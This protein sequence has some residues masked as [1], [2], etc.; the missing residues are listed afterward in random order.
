ML[1]NYLNTI[2]R[3]LRKNKT[4]SAINILG[5]ALAMSACLIIA[6]F[7][8][9][10]LGFDRYHS[11]A[12]RI[13]RIETE[14]WQEDVYQG[15]G[16]RSSP[17]M[18]QALAE[19]L[20]VVEQRAR[21]WDINYRNN[22]LTTK[23]EG[24]TLTYHEEGVYGAD[25]EVFAVFD[26]E[27][28][29]GGSD[30]FDEPG[31]MILTA[32][33]AI[34]YFE[35]FQSAIGTTVEMNGNDGAR[36]FEIVGI[37]QDLPAQTH[38]DFS[39]LFSMATRHMEG[40]E[41]KESWND[42]DTP[43]YLLLTSTEAKGVVLEEIQRLYDEHLQERF[44][45]Y[46]YEIRHHLIDLEDIHLYSRA[47]G[48]FNESVDALLVYGLLGVALI[49][50]IV[51][52]INYLNLSLVKTLDRLKEIGVRK[53]LGSHTKQITMLFTAEAAIVNVTA[54]LLAMT[55][56]Q[57][58]S[59][60]TQQLTGVPFSILDAWDVL[61]GLLATIIVGA[62]FIGLYP[63][64]MLSS[65]NTRNVLIGNR[66][67]QK[68]GGT[69]LRR[70]LVS[71][72]FIITFALIT[73]TVTAYKQITYMK[74]ADLGIDI[75]H[76][77]VVKAPP[78]DV[79]DGAQ[80]Q[81]Q[82]YNS[83]KTSLLQETGI[84]KVTNAGEI[85]GES[86]GWSTG[87]RLKNAPKSQSIQTGLISMGYDFLD[88]FELEAV[89]GR[90]LRQGDSPWSKGDVV[91]NEKL[92][93]QLG[94]ADPED[95][96]GAEIDGFWAPIQVRGVIEN[97]NHSSLHHD[98]S[99]I[100]YIISSWT[101]FYFIKLQVAEDLPPAQRLPEYRRLVGM[102]ESHWQET[103]D[104]NMD[105]YFLDQSFNSQYAKDEQFGKIFG[106][107]A[108][109]AIFIACMGLFGLT[110]FTLQQRT[111]EIGIRK[112]LGATLSQLVG[113]LVRNYLVILTVAYLIAMPLSWYLLSEWLSSYHFRI[114]I[115]AWMFIVPLVMVFGVSMSTVLYRV[116]GTVKSNPVDS[117]RYE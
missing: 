114:D 87:L 64:F 67:A 80:E 52:W 37:I 106:T 28:V 6:H 109:L 113:L 20:P 3:Q 88:F 16:T 22:T 58:S 25:K 35:D 13:V 19:A 7:V 79:R 61:L 72:Q 2:F 110:S 82:M 89:A 8:A 33:S 11:K 46:G 117:L 5:L 18:S 36:V 63:A 26:M 68:M 86:V 27:F 92:A 73:V 56:A 81:A 54:F 115:G 59:P 97:H 99:P 116:L 14:A 77:L 69:G 100:A 43:S 76:T 107:F 30:R 96:V 10:H 49:I 102:V 53:V 32:S 40:E 4:F 74:S 41:D 45:S 47:E 94:F 57:L 70:F 83:F 44:A 60:F 108:T 111:K 12:D 39:V 78:G 34:K 95:A 55:I 85:P 93:E 98:Y 91:I 15:V 9:F 103:F 66:Q 1:R 65:F 75:T 17:M 38:L 112:V 104:S 51:A 84:A 48:D 29:A 24:K 90:S 23:Q 50:L 31:T 101:E 105:Y 62:L 71:L 21:F 42:Y